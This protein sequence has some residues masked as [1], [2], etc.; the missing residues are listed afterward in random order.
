M[1]ILCSLMVFIRDKL[2]RKK[3]LTR[4]E[5]KFIYSKGPSS[6]DLPDGAN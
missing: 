2:E 1:E 5:N 6:F 3:E 4:V